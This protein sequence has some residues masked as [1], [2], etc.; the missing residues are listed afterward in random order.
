MG[1]ELEGVLRWERVFPGGCVG[2]GVEGLEKRNGTE[3][4]VLGRN[5]ALF[6]IVWDEWDGDGGKR[7]LVVGEMERSG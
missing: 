1:F 2:L 6:S 3:G 4:E 5:T 7:E